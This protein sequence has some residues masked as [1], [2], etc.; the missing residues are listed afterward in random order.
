M[1]TE[2]LL[3]RRGG[4]RGEKSVLTCVIPAVSHWYEQ[5]LI[6][7][8]FIYYLFSLGC[9]PLWIFLFLF[10]KKNKKKMGKATRMKEHCWQ[11]KMVIFL[12]FSE[13]TSKFYRNINLFFFPPFFNVVLQSTDK[14]KWLWHGHLISVRSFL[15]FT[16]KCCLRPET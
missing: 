4:R 5:Y 14:S 7:L 15:C 16:E 12:F 9:C 2:S 1:Y 8:F 11:E 10:L 6:S 3:K 13:N